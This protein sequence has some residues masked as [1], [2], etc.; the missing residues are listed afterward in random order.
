MDYMVIEV[1]MDYIEMKMEMEMEME[2]HM[3]VELVF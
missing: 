1:M 2:E 3:E